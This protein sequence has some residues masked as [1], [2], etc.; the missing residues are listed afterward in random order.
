MKS[1]KQNKPVATIKAGKNDS[2]LHFC[3]VVVFGWQ[4]HIV[5]PFSSERPIEVN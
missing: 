5:S 3:V 1:P 2:I 4:Y